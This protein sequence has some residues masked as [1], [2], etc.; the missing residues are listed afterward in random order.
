MHQTTHGYLLDPTIDINVISSI[1]GLGI[2][3]E[4]IYK[5]LIKRKLRE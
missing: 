4:L 1:N 3:R 2:D 5:Q